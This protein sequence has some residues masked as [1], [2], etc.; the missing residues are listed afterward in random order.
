MSLRTVLI[1]AAGLVGATAAQAET[2]AAAIPIA[3]RCWN[4]T[5]ACGSYVC[6]S[7]NV[8]G[9]MGCVREPKWCTQWCT[10]RVCS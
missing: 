6:G 3:S 2:P 9:Q 1:L 8:C 10:R 5:Y 7:H 4:Q